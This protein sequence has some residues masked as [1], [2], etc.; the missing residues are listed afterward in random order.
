MRFLL[1]FLI[2]L[3]KLAWSQGAATLVADDVTIADRNQLIATGNIEVFYDGTRLSAT[4]IVFD[5]AA[6]QLVINGPILIKGPDG[7]LITATQASMDPKLENGILRG[8]RLVLDQQL[9]LAAN[10]IDRI[11]GRYSQLYKVA[12]TSCAVCGTRAP[13]WEIRAEKVIH[14]QT[15]KQLYFENTQFLIR[16]THVLWLPRVRLPDP[17]LTRATGFLFPDARTTDQLGSGIKVPYFIRMGDHRDLTLT[18]YLSTETRTLEARYRQAFAT[19]DIEVNA[20]VSQD[21]LSS[22]TRSYVFAEGTFDLG[23]DYTLNFDIEAASDPAYLLDYGYSEKDRLDSAITLLR[24]GKDDLFQ[25][26]LT[27][28]Q[29]LRDDEDNASLPPIVGSLSYEKQQYL[30][31]G[32]RLRTG[33]SADTLSRYGS[34]SGDAAR[35]VTRIGA[36]ADYRH[37]WISNGGLVWA[38]DAGLRA[39]WYGVNDNADYDTSGTRIIPQIG[40]SLRYPLATT[41]ANG[42]SHLFEPVIAMAWSNTYG[43]PP[44]NEDSTR[45][46]FDQANLFSASRFSGDDAAEAGARAALGLTW[47]RLGAQGAQSTLTFGRVFRDHDTTDF[48]S[49]SGLDGWSSDWLVAGQYATTTGFQVDGRTLF[50]ADG[51]TRAAARVGWSNAFTDLNSAYIWQAADLAENRPNNVS[52]WA[53]ESR[54]QVTPSWAVGIDTRYDIATNSPVRAGLDVQYKNE[55]V[56]VDLSVSRR[57][58]SSSTVE[59][60]NSYGLSISLKGFSAGHN[61]AGPLAACAQ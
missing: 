11:N 7:S 30:E 19:G 57:Y 60:S 14:D 54:V 46:E 31:N 16:G 6:D 18:P 36:F 1:V 42:A 41:T 53:L 28:F 27:Y 2:L 35:D 40:A 22:G 26:N 8:A 33:L 25:A 56:T 20:A 38:A 50:D 34:G 17:T 47:T 15:A 29:T 52:E 51:I 45:S 37:Q 59:P 24:V 58:T 23:R 4:Q 13:L 12:A 32:G 10:Q 49:S 44:P 55:C 39:D 5:R 43:T 48:N 61:G 21:S 3:P 9:Q